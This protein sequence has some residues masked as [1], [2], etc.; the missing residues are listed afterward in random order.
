MDGMLNSADIAS[1][2][3][4]ALDFTIIMNVFAVNFLLKKQ[5]MITTAA[6]VD[7]VQVHLKY[8]VWMVLLVWSWRMKQR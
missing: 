4:A 8:Q 3:G 5:L 7:L 6:V 1:G 2:L